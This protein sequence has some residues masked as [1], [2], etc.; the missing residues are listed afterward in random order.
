MIIA[1]FTLVAVLPNCI[2]NVIKKQNPQIIPTTSRAANM[3][4]SNMRHRIPPNNDGPPHR[5]ILLNGDQ[6]LYLQHCLASLPTHYQ[7]YSSNSS[8]A[9]HQPFTFAPHGV[10]QQPNILVNSS[11]PQN[12]RTFFRPCCILEPDPNLPS[13]Y[14]AA[15][16]SFG[17]GRGLELPYST[18]LHSRYSYD[19]FIPSRSHIHGQSRAP[20]HIDVFQVEAQRIACDFLR[21]GI[22]QVKTAEEILKMQLCLLP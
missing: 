14:R 1:Q 18:G 20:S 5:R 15:D 10:Y 19:S 21:V 3:P 6:P 22:E 17:D 8:S 16:G 2:D 9:Y 4:E 12:A 7:Q 11:T 13:S